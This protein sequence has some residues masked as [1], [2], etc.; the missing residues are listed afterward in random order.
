M[1]EENTKMPIRQAQDRLQQEEKIETPAMNTGQE[2]RNLEIEKERGE[3]EKKIETDDKIDSGLSKPQVEPEIARPDE[4]KPIGQDTESKQNITQQEPVIIST[5]QTN[6]E[7][8]VAQG[9]TG[10]SQE[11]IEEKS[12]SS[13]STE[14]DVPSNE[15][16][17]LR[18]AFKNFNTY[19]IKFDNRKLKTYEYIVLG[20]TIS[21][22]IVSIFL[23]FSSLNGPKISE[24][25]LQNPERGLPIQD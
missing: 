14:Q 4:N 12:S 13:V 15:V 21:V 23:F 11:P 7:Q 16:L 19:S 5:P 22:I 10:L 3:G 20:V 17:D 25:I 24:E 2:L 9:P 8:S 6:E 1:E 18:D